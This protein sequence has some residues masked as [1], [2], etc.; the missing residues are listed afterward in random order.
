MCTPEI[1]GKSAADDCS[2]SRGMSNAVQSF[3]IIGIILLIISDVWIQIFF[4]NSKIY[5][6]DSTCIERD[7]IFLLEWS[8]Y[9]WILTFFTAVKYTESY[10]YYIL[11]LIIEASAS[12]YLYIRINYTMASFTYANSSFRRGNGTAVGFLLALHFALLLDELC[13]TSEYYSD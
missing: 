3:S 7:G 12:F 6:K 1:L 10:S 9:K 8:I 11:F 13:R 4:N 5:K 2:T